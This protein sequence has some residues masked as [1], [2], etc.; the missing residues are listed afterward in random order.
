[1]DELDLLVSW[2]KNKA[3]YSNKSS[4]RTGLAGSEYQI[5]LE[6]QLRMSTGQLKAGSRP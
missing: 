2:G 6:T 1:M 5:Q 3:Q 4:Q